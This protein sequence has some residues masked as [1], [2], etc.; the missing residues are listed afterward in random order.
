MG[1]TTMTVQAEEPDRSYAC[2]RGH[3][4]TGRIESFSMALPE[5]PD[6]ASAGGDREAT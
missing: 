4:M 1:I 3:S 2:K 5:T 6:R